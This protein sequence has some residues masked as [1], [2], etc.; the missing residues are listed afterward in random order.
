MASTGTV[1]QT[2]IKLN[3]NNLATGDK[4]IKFHYFSTNCQGITVA[5]IIEDGKGDTF[6]VNIHTYIYIQDPENKQ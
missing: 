2:H 4:R 6:D 3:A 5:I 1:K